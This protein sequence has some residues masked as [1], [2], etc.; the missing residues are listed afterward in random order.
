MEVFVG[1]A[2]PTK[3]TAFRAWSNAAG[4]MINASFCAGIIW[5]TPFP[6]AWLRVG[7]EVLAGCALPT[8]RT[9]FRIRW[10]VDGTMISALSRYGVLCS[11]VIITY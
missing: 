6:Y 2:L 8:K 11:K 7:I 1:W 9:V 3:K 4:T 5:E 10:D